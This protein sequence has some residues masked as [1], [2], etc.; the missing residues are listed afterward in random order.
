VLGLPVT[1]VAIAVTLWVI[2]RLHRHRS[3]PPPPA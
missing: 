2:A 3:A 1:A